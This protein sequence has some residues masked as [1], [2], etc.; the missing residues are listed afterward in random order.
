MS[1][2]DRYDFY[3]EYDDGPR[4]FNRRP[5]QK[6]MVWTTGQGEIIPITEMEDSHIQ[7]TINYQLIGDRVLAFRLRRRSPSNFLGLVRDKIKRNPIHT[8]TLTRRSRAI[9]KNMAKMPTTAST[10]HLYP[11][12]K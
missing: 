2:E 10:M 11:S 8:I 6:Q 5:K 9:I 3:D 4:F 1:Y 7:N 12:H